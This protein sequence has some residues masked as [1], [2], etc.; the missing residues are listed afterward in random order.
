MSHDDITPAETD[1]QWLSAADALDGWLDRH[2]A[3]A[4]ALVLAGQELMARRQTAMVTPTA[5]EQTRKPS[6]PDVNAPRYRLKLPVKPR[7]LGF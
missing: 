1:I 7:K 6:R 5:E 4:K 3:H 2:P